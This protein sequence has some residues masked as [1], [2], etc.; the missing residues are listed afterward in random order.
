MY[1][2][3]LA[4]EKVKAALAADIERASLP[5]TLLFSGPAASGKLTAAL[6]TARLL[7]CSRG[8][9][10]NC[11]CPDCARHRFLAHGDLLLFGRRSFPEEIA[12]AKE[13]FLRA[14]SQ[15]SAFF[16]LRAFRKLLARFNPVLWAG[17]EAKLGKA[18]SLI[19]SIE[20]GLAAID[21]D[22]MGAEISSDLNKTVASLTADAGALEALAPE[23]PGV[24]MI[25]NMGMWAQ[26]SPWGKC[27]TIIVENADSMQDSARNAMLKL[28]EEPPA[29]ARFI[30]LTS[31]RAS[32]IATILSRARLYSFAARDAEATALV[33]S[34]VF[35]T[36]EKAPSLQAFLESR[37]AFPPA[38]AR[39]YAE[40]F[41]GRLLLDLDDASLMGPSYGPSLARQAETSGAALTEILDEIGA[42][43]GGF[44]SK[45]KAMA[46]SFTYFIKALLSVFS[47]LLKE[48]RDNPALI[49]LLER[50]S[51]LAR[52][53]AVQYGALNRSPDLLIKVLAASYGDGI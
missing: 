48:S 34:K 38:A 49:A 7:S 21:P 31:R 51:R 5:P 53:A 33:L 18:A 8:G 6:E 10:W 40:R 9:E 42:A 23:A 43:T 30:L 44:G 25:R 3:L 41:V 24:F 28:L 37:R 22:A 52:E 16:F 50:W 27:K 35:K 1:E 36:Q 14:P 11:S 29:A 12:L 20:E 32:M 2:N 46:A 45:D 13:F 17:E 26:L 4:Q 15:A 47:D 19:Q 39:G